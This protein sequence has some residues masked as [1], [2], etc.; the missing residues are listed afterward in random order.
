MENTKKAWILSSLAFLLL[1]CAWELA[2]SL[3]GWS[4]HVF[5]GPLQVLAG[6]GELAAN[7][8]LLRH[9]VA[10]LYRVTA[11]FYLAVGLGI[12]LGIVM[13]YWTWM[14]MLINPLVQFLR[15]ISPLAWIPL[16][17]LWFGIGDK[18]A[19]FL[20]FLSSFFPLVVSTTVAVSSINPVY[21]QVASNFNFS[22]WE[23][24][25]KIIMPAIIPSVVT[26]LRI[27]ITI[28]WLVVVAAEMI[29][30]QSG[31]GY[32]ILDSRNALRMDYV[33]DGM[34]VIG[35]IGILLDYF[36]RKLGHIDTA[37]W[38]TLGRHVS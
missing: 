21:F 8:T 14:K 32:L 23:T 11:G 36:M 30:V 29:A 25:T 13:G 9:S 37:L 24:I 19:I 33:M 22:R 16:A 15:P 10:S 4:A 1:L 31:L 6:M 38:S 35:I 17:M 18:P 2:A 3:S 20:I 12:P 28:A 7:G 27:T 34:I 26:A 5:P